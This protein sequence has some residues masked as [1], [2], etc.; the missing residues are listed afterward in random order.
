MGKTHS[1]IL[2]HQ[3]KKYNLLNLQTQPVRFSLPE[4]LRYEDC[5]VL[6]QFCTKI[7]RYCLSPCT[8]RY[9]CESM[10]KISIEFCQRELTI[11]TLFVSKTLHQNLIERNWPNHI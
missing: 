11:I 5:A 8:G 2:I 10:R 3:G 1:F 7:I 4:G 9:S 6:G